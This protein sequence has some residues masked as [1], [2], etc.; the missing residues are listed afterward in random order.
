MDS[1]M[2]MEV[3]NSENPPMK[4]VDIRISNDI[5]WALASALENG[6]KYATISEFCDTVQNGDC[7]GYS[8]WH[9]LVR[10]MET[11]QC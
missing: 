1:K 11:K 6:N 5:Y 10:S 4:P 8:A 3:I 7:D 9:A 2:W